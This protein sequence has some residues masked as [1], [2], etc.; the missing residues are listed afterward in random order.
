VASRLPNGFLWIVQSLP[1]GLACGRSLDASQRPYGIAPGFNGRRG[2]KGCCQIRHCLPS[3]LAEILDRTVAHSWPWFIQQSH[4]IRPFHARPIQLQPTR[5]LNPRSILSADAVNRS[6]HVSLG[7]LRGWAAQLV[8]GASVNNDQAAIGV[9]QH[10][11]RMEVRI[12]GNQKIAI[13]RV[14]GR[15]RRRQT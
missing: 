6:Q 5:V 1:D 4:E 8:P 15:T 11:R 10:I 7:E 3:S 9:F 12:G 2:A 13:L 14:E